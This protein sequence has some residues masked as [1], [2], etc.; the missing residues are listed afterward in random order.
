MSW[1][2]EEIDENLEKFLKQNENEIPLRHQLSKHLSLILKMR[3]SKIT[4]KKILTFLMQNDEVLKKRY[5]GREHAGIS[6]LS[7][8]LKSQ[9]D[10]VK[11]CNKTDKI[12]SLKSKKKKGINEQHSLKKEFS[13]EEK[14]RKLEDAFELL[15]SKKHSFKTYTKKQIDT[16]YAKLDEET[17]I[18]S[19]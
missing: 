6:M 13:T 14:I 12:K 5:E 8:F 3:E 11:R 17:D 1:K 19:R 2:K 15:T 9:K 7:Y 4:L 18:S 16:A 10:E